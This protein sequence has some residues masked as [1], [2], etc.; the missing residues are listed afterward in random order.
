M[1]T[2]KYQVSGWEFPTQKF[3]WRGVVKEHVV[4]LPLSV[5]QCRGLRLEGRLSMQTAAFAF[6]Q[7]GEC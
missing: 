4:L 3:D 6:Q 5:K 2:Q 1:Q 7:V